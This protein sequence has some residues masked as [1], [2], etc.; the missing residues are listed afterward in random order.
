MWVALVRR[1]SDNPS[2]RLLERHHVLESLTEY[3]YSARGS[4]GRLVL[5]SGEAGVG[6]SSLVEQFELATPDARWARGA[7]DGLFTPRPLGPLFDIG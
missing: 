4:E 6:K 3:A 5:I 2:V 7:C 1:E